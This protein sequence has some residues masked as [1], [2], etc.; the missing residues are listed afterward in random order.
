VIDRIA[1]H[2]DDHPAAIGAA[3]FC[4]GPFNPAGRPVLV[5]VLLEIVSSPVAK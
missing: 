5:W 1:H 4:N 2:H 3:D